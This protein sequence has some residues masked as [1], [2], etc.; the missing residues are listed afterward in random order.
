MKETIMLAREE[1]RA[2]NEHLYEAL[3]FLAIERLFL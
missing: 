1:R 3:N 2:L